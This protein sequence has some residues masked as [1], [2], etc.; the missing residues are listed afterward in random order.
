MIISAKTF[1][2]GDGKAVLNDAALC[3]EKD[4]IIDAGPAGDIRAKYPGHELI[5]YGDAT[6]LPGLIDMHVHLAYWFMRPDKE[7]YDDF[8]VAYFA[9][10]NAQRALFSGV[11]TVRDVFGPSGACRQLALAASRGLVR[12]PRIIHCNRCLCIT[13]GLDW[14]SGG[15]SVQVDGEAEVVKAVRTEIREGAQWIKMMTSGRAQG[16][17]EFSQAEMNAAVNEVHRLGK[18]IAAHSTSQPSLQMCIDA[19]YDTIEHGTHLTLDQAK[20][21]RDKGIA[22]VPTI[23]IHKFI[24]ERLV[25]KINESGYESLTEREQRTHWGYERSM[26]AYTDNFLNL[27]DTGVTVLAGTDMVFDGENPAPVSEELKCMTDLGFDNLRAVAT[28]TSSAGK[29]LGMENEIGSLRPGL[30]ADIL[31]VKGDVSKDIGALKNVEAVY[32]D[33]KIIS[34]EI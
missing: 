32:L 23:F 28:A 33:G 26:K 1:I 13:G 27:A 14:Q 9:L 8:M 29:V 31:I 15:G 12:S 34:R 24:F 30:K 5:D 16:V 3:F 25:K 20:Q 4:R 17:A 10:N 7:I 21:I 22:W 2:N 19:G 6:I 18:K 11:T